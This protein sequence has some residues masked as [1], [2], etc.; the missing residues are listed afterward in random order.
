[1][2]NYINVK[3][4]FLLTLLHFGKILS[5]CIGLFVLTFVESLQ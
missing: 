3:L 2:V 1:M 5:M 4:S